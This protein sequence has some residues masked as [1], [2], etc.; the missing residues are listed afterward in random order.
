MSFADIVALTLH[1][2]KNRLAQLAGS[3]EA[4]GDTETMRQAIEAADKLTS[5]LIYYRSDMGSLTLD[6]D[7]HSPADL[8]AEFVDQTAARGP[9]RVE[10]DCTQAPTLW[11]YDEALLRMVLANAVQNAGRHARTR[12]LIRVAEQGGLL[13]FRVEDDGCGFPDEVL[14]AVLG[15]AAHV[16]REGTGLGLEL[17]RRIARMHQNAGQR[18]QI[19]LENAGGA[20]FRLLLPP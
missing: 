12:I 5:L 1:D 20:V 18:G 8:A 3:A 17:A 14:A 10:L 7:G 16:T 15:D 19:R 6:I 13:E 11:F 9:C 4:R 2:V